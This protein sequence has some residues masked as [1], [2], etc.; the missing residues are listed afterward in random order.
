MRGRWASL[1][2]ARPDDAY[3]LANR[4]L[5]C[6]NKPGFVGYAR[7][8]MGDIATGPVRF[9]TA[10]AEIHYREALAL[11]EPCGMRPLLAHCH[12]GLGR[13]YRRID[14]RQQSDEHP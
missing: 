8:L 4:A 14:K 2:L 11:A 6:V 12:F 7:H 3:R 1:V 9:D 13:L 5:E 10:G